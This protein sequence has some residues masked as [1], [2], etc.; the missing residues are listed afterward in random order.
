MASQGSNPLR[1]KVGVVRVRKNLYN[2]DEVEVANLRKAFEGLYQISEESGDDERGYQW[3][4]GVHGFPVPVYCQHGNANFPTWHRPYVYE[5]ELRLQEIV[6]SVMMPYWDWTSE[7]TAEEGIPAILAERTYV[8]A[9]SGETKP[10]PL[11]AARNPNTGRMTRRRPGPLS[12]FSILQDQIAF[13][14]ERTT[15]DAFW[16]ALENPH[17]GIH[18][19]VGGDMG[20]VPYAAFDPIFWFHHTNVDRQW[21]LWQQEHGDA[22][23]PPPVRAF[24][25]APFTYT[26]EEALDAGYFGYTYAEDEAYASFEDAEVPETEA[27]L[28]PVMS[29]DLRQLKPDF[30]SAHLEFLDL[31][32]TKDSYQVR[33]YCDGGE[34]GYTA[35]TERVGNERH[36]G[37]LYL[38]GHGECGGATGHCDLP[39]RGRFDRRPPHHLLPYNTFID[40]TGA[41][42]RAT[43]SDAPKITLSFVVVDADGKQV[44]PSVIEFEGLSLVTRK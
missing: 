9:E 14:L 5:F 2:L 42:K 28:P 39:T 16:P 41:V 23:V 37:T 35:A 38:F 17:G 19:W 8:D 12:E 20:V 13:A 26:G 22:T 25:C 18:V 34:G 33:V 1:D 3:I 6:P 4:A 43:E 31:R 40:V 21:W 10:N 30:T 24:V 15:Y 29:F 32:R 7:Q 27:L 11:F 36:A 44:P